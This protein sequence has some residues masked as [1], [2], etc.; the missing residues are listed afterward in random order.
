MK[1]WIKYTRTN[2]KSVAI[3]VPNGDSHPSS[4]R[5]CI[6]Y[7]KYG[8]NDGNLFLRTYACMV[9]EDEISGNAYH[10]S[11]PEHVKLFS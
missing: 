1:D 6:H 7:I 9:A 4:S 3:V 5:T 11:N 10:L 2:L 8:V